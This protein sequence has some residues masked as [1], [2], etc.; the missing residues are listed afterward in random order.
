MSEFS[1]EH[2]EK[3]APALAAGLT[4]TNALVAQVSGS[5]LSEQS[6]YD[7]LHELA[8]KQAQFQQAIVRRWEFRWRRRWRRSANRRGRNFFGG[9]GPT[10][11]FAYAVPGQEFAV[12]VHIDNPGASAVTLTRVWVETPRGVLGDCAGTAGARERGGGP[13]D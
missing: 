7:V 3:I 10:E 4:Q 11:T 6:K 13:G 8:A 9:A 2:P 1:V 12:K 5:G